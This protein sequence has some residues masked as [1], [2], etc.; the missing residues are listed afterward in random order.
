MFNIIYFYCVIVIR[1]EK[2][3]CVFLEVDVIV[4]WFLFYGFVCIV[5]ELD[6]KVGGCYWMVFC[7]FMIGGS[8]LFGGIYFEFVVNEC[9]VYFDSFDI[10]SFL[11]E[12]WMIIILKV[13]LMGM[14]VNIE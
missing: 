11:G 6:V 4:S 2:I 14:E 10:E 3:Y 7:N 9:I 5:Y 1:F 8:Y 13:N 12:M